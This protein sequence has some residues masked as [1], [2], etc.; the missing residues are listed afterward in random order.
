MLENKAEVIK[1][2]SLFNDALGTLLGH[3]FAALERKEKKGGPGA[4]RV[5]NIR[6]NAAATRVSDL[7]WHAHENGLDVDGSR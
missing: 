5:N 4:M 7:R 3:V 1:M 6:W 2:T